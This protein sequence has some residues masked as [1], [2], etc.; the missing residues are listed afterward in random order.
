MDGLS[1]KLFKLAL[2]ANVRIGQNQQGLRFAMRQACILRVARNENETIIRSCF[3]SC[4][5]MWSVGFECVKC[6]G[7]V[8][9]SLVNRVISSLFKFGTDVDIQIQT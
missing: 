2:C 1:A 6:L 4:L 5:L 8:V 3:E 9:L 7:G